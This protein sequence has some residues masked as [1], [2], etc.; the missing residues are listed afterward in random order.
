MGGMRQQLYLGR[1]GKGFSGNAL[2]SG[3]WSMNKSLPRRSEENGS[4]KD[5]TPREAAPMRVRP[6]REQRASSRAAF[7]NCDG[8]TNPLGG[9]TDPQVP[10]R[11]GSRQGAETLFLAPR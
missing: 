11:R 7:S 6:R 4:K 2:R 1:S 5:M 3:I 9:L 8:N 10:M